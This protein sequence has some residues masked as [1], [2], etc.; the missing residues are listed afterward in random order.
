MTHFKDIILESLVD[1]NYKRKT[2]HV[3]VVVALANHSTS[4]DDLRPRKKIG[5]NWA[6]ATVD[7]VFLSHDANNN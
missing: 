1:S 6:L 3:R 5:P 7:F 2:F 4:S